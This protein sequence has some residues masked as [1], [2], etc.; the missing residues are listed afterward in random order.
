MLLTN[1]GGKGAEN[2]L[3]YK[4]EALRNIRIHK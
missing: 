4:E 3:Y 1:V 2:S